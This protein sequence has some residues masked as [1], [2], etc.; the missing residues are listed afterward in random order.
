MNLA[1]VFWNGSDLLALALLIVCA[2]AA[3]CVKRSKGSP[4]PSSE[5]TSAH[6]I[7]VVLDL[8]PHGSFTVEIAGRPSFGLVHFQEFEVFPQDT[9]MAVHQRIAAWAVKLPFI[10]TAEASPA[11]CRLVSSRVLEISGRINGQGID[12]FFDGG[13]R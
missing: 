1:T 12:L 2:I 8:D 5:T 6:S 10:S 9:T 7:E 3:G 4:P 11:G 13:Q